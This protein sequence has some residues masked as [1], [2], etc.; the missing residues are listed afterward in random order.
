MV[1]RITILITASPLCNNNS[2]ERGTLMGPGRYT[3]NGTLMDALWHKNSIVQFIQTY[4]GGCSCGDE[5]VVVS[6]FV[7]LSQ[8]YNCCD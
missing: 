5:S 1:H 4:P 8:L 3:S 7:C 2:R 6:L